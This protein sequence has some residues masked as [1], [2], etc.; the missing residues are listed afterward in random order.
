MT[1]ALAHD[2]E[3]DVFKSNFKDLLKDLNMK[4]NVDSIKQ[5]LVEVSDSKNWEGAYAELVALSVLN[6][7]YSGAITTDVTLDEGMSFAKECGKKYTNEDGYWKDFDA[8]FDVKILSDPIKEI[9]DGIIKRAEQMAK[10]VGKCSILPEYPLDDN[11]DEYRNSIR[12]IEQELVAALNNKD[13]IARITRPSHLS[14]RIQWGGGINMV[15]STYSPFC[16]AEHTKDIVLKRYA[17]KLV[18]KKPFFLVFVNFSWFKQLVTDF[19]NMNEYY[20]RALSRR[21]FIQ[22]E[23]SRSKANEI[24]DGYIGKETKRRLARCLTGIIFIEDHSVKEKEKKYKSF[25]YLNPN[26]YNRVKS[27]R[28]Y[29]HQL[30]NEMIEDFQYDNY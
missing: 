6:N 13:T 16:Y 30:P 4:Y 2:G 17:N 22:Y 11:A 12:L 24:V 15:Q 21:T 9:L 1:G 26:A 10:V 18:K 8:Y 7:D 5:A 23:R 20:Y 3:Y 19:A 29:L 14:F 25:V 28:G 27:L